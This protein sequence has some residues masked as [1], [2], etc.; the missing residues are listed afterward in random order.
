MSDL[1]YFEAHNQAWVPMA[2][3]V[4]LLNLMARLEPTGVL[5]ELRSATD[6]ARVG[7]L[8]HL[9]EDT[10]RR[11]LKTL[12]LFEVVRRVDDTFILTPAWS[13][14][15]D[16]GAFMPLRTLISGEDT[17]G[18][19]LRTLGEV[20]YW[21][22]SAERRLTVACAISPDP[23]SERLVEAYRAGLEADPV[24]REILR[25]GRFLELGCGVAGRILLT[26]RAAPTLTAVGIELSPD[27]AAEAERRAVELGVSDRFTVIC[28]DAGD[29]VAGE[30]FDF[31]F[32]SQ[33]FFPDHARQAALRVM[34]ASLR[35]GA[36][37]QAPIGV[38]P[39]AAERDLE[40]AKEQAVMSTM[41]GA[42]GVPERGIDELKDELGR[43][44]F[45]DLEVIAREAGPAVRA[46][47]PAS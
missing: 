18:G 25:G 4:A 20:D 16:P 11:L 29:Y 35:P 21:Q 39:A 14:L 22:L 31:G 19:V 38:D 1:S 43:A 6:V 7:D 47:R 2:N 10:A 40:I 46:W 17:I 32:W 23:Y 37:F 30:P 5:T 42:W 12:E 9:S 27:L 3:S 8:A 15:T 28:G 45:T 26:L 36:S 13:A 34:M 24:G 41:L 33:F 44:G